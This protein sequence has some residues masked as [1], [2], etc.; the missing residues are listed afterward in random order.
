MGLVLQSVRRVDR[1]EVIGD[2]D[3]Y[4]RE[5]R[6]SSSEKSQEDLKSITQTDSDEEEKEDLTTILNDLAD[7]D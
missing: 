3:Q 5:S 1:G 6:S 4:R 7:M 2:H